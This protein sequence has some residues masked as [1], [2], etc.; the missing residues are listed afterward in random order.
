MPHG[1]NYFQKKE[2]DAA[3]GKTRVKKKT[4]PANT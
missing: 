1:K 3:G 2:K 4:K